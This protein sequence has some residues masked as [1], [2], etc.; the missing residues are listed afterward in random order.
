MGISG[1]SLDS[2]YRSAD[3]IPRL[4][5]TGLSICIQV[6]QMNP[7]SCPFAIKSLSAADPESDIVSRALNIFHSLTLKPT[8][9]Y[10]NE[11][12]EY[13]DLSGRMAGALDSPVGFLNFT[14]Y[15]LKAEA[16]TSN[17]DTQMKRS[18]MNETF[19]NMPV[20]APLAGSSNPFAIA[21]RLCY[22]N[23]FAG[24][25]TQA[26][27]VDYLS[28]QLATLDPIVAYSSIST[29]VCLGWPNLTAYDLE[30]FTGSFPKTL[31]NKMLVVG[32]TDS[33]LNSFAGS[34]R[35]YNYIGENNS[36]FLSHEGFGVGTMFTPNN[37]TTTILRDYFTTGM[38]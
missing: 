37:C 31:K 14:Q 20:E 29:A 7:E 2:T 17:P 12:F 36:V 18:V 11:T 3:Q 1:N 10:Q 24:I 25:D 16:A 35:T 19:A 6:A 33:A 30:R 21:G 32:V 28:K 34:L 4:L 27:F 23:S 15:L 13:G 22:D 26:T 8:Y 9:T 38:S 5:S